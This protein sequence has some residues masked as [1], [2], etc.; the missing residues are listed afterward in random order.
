MTHPEIQKLLNLADITQEFEHVN[1]KLVDHWCAL[2]EEH[3]LAKLL[4]LIQE[5]VTTKN[6]TPA[7]T[8]EPETPKQNPPLVQ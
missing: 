5:H 3:G 4:L 1:L 7:Q 2:R 8:P 6:L